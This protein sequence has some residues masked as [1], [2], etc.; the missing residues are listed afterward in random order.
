VLRPLLD[1]H[2]DNLQTA[3]EVDILCHLREGKIVIVDLSLGDPNIQRIFSER[4]C[5]HI[6]NDAV[7][8][9]T[10]AKPNNFIQFYFEEAH[11]LFPE[12]RGQRSLTNLQPTCQRGRQTPSRPSLCHTGS[13]L[14]Q[15]WFSINFGLRRLYGKKQNGQICRD[16]KGRMLRP[17]SAQKDPDLHSGIGDGTTHNDWPAIAARRMTS[18]TAAKEKRGSDLPGSKNTR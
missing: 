17:L 15:W 3:F 12:K 7:A 8:R 16:K 5:K 9:F 1:H 18:R 11:N 10:E 13:E 6:F 4:V 2:T 14:R